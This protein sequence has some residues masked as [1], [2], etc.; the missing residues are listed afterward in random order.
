MHTDDD[1]NWV[2]VKVT[3]NSGK[4]QAD[5]FVVEHAT[6]FLYE[7]PAN[8]VVAPTLVAILGPG[9]WFSLEPV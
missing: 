6:L 8:P 3:T 1:V 7:Q 9:G 5:G 2:R 4:R